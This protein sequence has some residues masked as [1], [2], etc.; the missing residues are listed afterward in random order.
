MSG[1]RWEGRSEEGRE[2][3]D[4]TACVYEISDQFVGVKQDQRVKRGR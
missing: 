2:A 4:E 3:C 1:S